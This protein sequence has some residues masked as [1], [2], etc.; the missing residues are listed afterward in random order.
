MARLRASHR[1]AALTLQSAPP[2]SVHASGVLVLHWGESATL[3]HYFRRPQV[4]GLPIVG[5]IDL[6]RGESLPEIG[7]DVL[8]LI[9][10]Y[11]S[12]QALPGLELHRR[13][14]G[15]IALFMD[16]D[17]PGNIFDTSLPLAY[18]RTIWQRFGRHQKSLEALCSELWVSTPALAHRYAHAAPRVV[19]PHGIPSSTARDCVSYF[20]HGS[21]STHREDIDW[22]RAVVEQTQARDESL[23]FMVIGD[24]QVKALFADLPRCLILH[25]MPWPTY[26]DMLPAFPHHI[27]LAPLR[28]TDFN[29][30]RSPTRFF[31]FTRLGAAGIYSDAEPYRSFIRDGKDGCLLSDD[32]LRWSDKIIEWA[33]RPE[34]RARI[35]AE[36]RNR[37]G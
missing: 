33:Q 2:E 5:Y 13:R 7:S 37:C 9:V 28:P 34:L 11:T 10:R 17:L 32:P 27:G 1:Q 36:A 14:G 31:D 12:D 25:S 19:V 18:R 15:R 35:V 24:R 23:L 29:A 4:L 6:A 16:D 26:R 21:P 3:D 20:Y 8:L 22:L 30:T